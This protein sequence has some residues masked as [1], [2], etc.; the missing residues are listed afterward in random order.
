MD[1]NENKSKLRSYQASLRQKSETLHKLH[2][3]A[4]PMITEGKSIDDEIDDVSEFEMNLQEYIIKVDQWLKNCYD[5]NQ[6]TMD[7]DNI[8]RTFRAPVS[9]CGK[10]EQFGSI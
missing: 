6:R 5:L 1:L 2:A 8:F 10:S 7:I 3:D 4:L 9:W